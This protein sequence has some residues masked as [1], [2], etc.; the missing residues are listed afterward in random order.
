[1]ASTKL[2]ECLEACRFNEPVDRG[3]FRCRL[4]ILAD[5]HEIDIG[6]AKIIHQL[7]N[8]LVTLAKA[9][10]DPR[11]REDRRVEPFDLLQDRQG[12]EVARPGLIDG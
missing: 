3:V 6:A 12:M 7:A 2:C 4:Q 9:D 8:L 10:H 5:G 1:M 11:L